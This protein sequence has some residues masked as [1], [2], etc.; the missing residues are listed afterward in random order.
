MT[1]RIS[2]RAIACALLATTCLCLPTIAL[3]DSP[4]PK[5]I[6]AIDD[7]EVDLV[8]GLPFLSIEEGGIGS[9]P[10]RVA[11]TR[12]WA[13][14]AGFQDNWSGGLFD[15]T[16]GGVTKK[17]VQINGISDTFTQSGSTYTADKANGATL[18]YDS[19]T[20]QFVY[21]ASDGTKITFNGT[22]G[23]GP[24]G[25]GDYCPGS[26]GA[27]CHVPTLIV[28]PNGLKFTLSW[29]FVTL[30]LHHIGVDCDSEAVYFRLRSVSS[31]AGYSMAISYATNSA[32]TGTEP[33]SLWY[34]R[35]SVTFNNSANP[36]SP[37]SSISYAYPSSTTT[38]VTDPASRTW[39]FTT[40]ANG[41]LTGVQRPGSSSNN[42][43][44]AYGA[45]GTISSVTKDGVTNSYSRST[46]G[47]TATET[48]TN[49]LSQQRV[50]TTD[51]SKGRPTS[52]KD[53]LNRT[54]SYQYDANV[55]MTRITAPEGNYV[56]YD[57]DARGNVNTTT[58][59]A[60]AGSGLANIVTNANF[61]ATCTNIVKCNKPNSTTDAKGNVTNYTYDPTHGG[62]LTITSPAPSAGAV[63]PQTRIT[64]SQVTSASGDLVY[65]PTKTAACQTLASC[66]NGADEAQVITAY[67]GNLLPTS[68]TRQDGTATL[69]S[70]STSTYDPRGNVLTVDGQLA[71]SGDT[72]R[73]RYDNADQL[74]GVTSPDPDGSGPLK[75]RAV[76]YSYNPDGTLWLAQYGTV[77]DQSD[78]AW[79]NFAE[80]YHHYRQYDS[81]AHVIRE[82]LWSNGVDYAVT[83]H[84]YDGLGR[85]SCSVQYMDPAVWGPQ[86]T[87]CAPLQTN[88]PNGPDRVTQTVY[89][90]AS[91]P[92]Q[93][94]VAVGT[95]DA[96]TERTLTYSNNGLVTSLTDGESNKTS[97]VYDGFDRLSQ[98]QY[99][100]ATKGAGTSNA[101][102]YEQLGY[103]AAS[104]VTSRRLRDGTS[105]AYGYDNLDRVTLK[106]LPGSESDV[107][108]S[109]DLLGRLTG[110]S[111]GGYNLTF[112]YDALSRQTSD[113]QGWG[114]ISRSFDAAGR[115]TRLTWQDGFYV[116][117]DRLVTGELSKVRE[118]GATSGVGVLATYGYDDLGRRTSLTFGN[119][120]SQVYSYDAVGRLASLTNDLSGT[121]N[122][123]SVTFA[124]NPASQ[125]AS[126]VRT[127]D[128]YAFTGLA[129]ANTGY[130]QNGLNQQVTIG[131]SSASWDARGNL[132]AD[133]A[134]GKTYTYN[135]ENRLTSA[136]GGVSLYYDPIGRLSEYDTNVSS[137]FM[138]D[139]AEIAVEVDNPAGNVVRRFVRGDGPDELIAWYEG[140]G[141]SNRRFAST[142][143]RGSVISATDSSGALVGI[144]TYD[145]YGKPG[146]AS[147]GR[148]QYTGQMW[149]PEA[150]VYNYKAR[151]YSPT[152]GRFM[153]TDPIGYGNGPNWYAYVGSDPVNHTDPLGLRWITRCVGVV[154][155]TQCDRVWVEDPVTS[156]TNRDNSLKSPG[157][158]NGGPSDDDSPI[159]ITAPKLKPTIGRYH[160]YQIVRITQ[161]SAAEAFDAFKA[162][163]ASAPGAP[164]A[165]EG[166][167]DR[168]VLN[169]NNPIS[170]YVNTKNM[171]IINRALP[172]HRYFPG[173]VTIQVSP[174]GS[175]S[176]ITIVGTGSGARPAENLLTGNAFFG[177]IATAIMQGCAILEGNVPSFG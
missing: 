12:I 14:G 105:I 118:N 142:D 70:T 44:F 176:K 140:S 58:H 15:V 96:A 143:E 139:G 72:T 28:A 79:S 99:P 134:S 127:G 36:P 46:V 138:S 136:S 110:A 164:Q 21:T 153:Q 129:N 165:R 11:M 2:R 77:T 123:L 159:V 8:T 102:D 148:F 87:S 112:G 116:D 25:T 174:V 157:D 61:D 68:V 126:A 32:G 94:K 167:T 78:S 154:G 95:S 82:T 24:A 133:P 75:D 43:S 55:R 115:A 65:M 6:D 106:D 124:Y 67:N 151:M 146:S 170:Q 29:D 107:S 27:S 97:Y 52:D 149:L 23:T 9:G 168:L 40:D 18:V 51:T 162:P 169:G 172:G 63:Q 92:T 155:S 83:D 108:Y 163:G 80:A 121:A 135:S 56:R 71:G 160:R 156:W 103:D 113:G 89:D 74:I 5:F 22:M 66:A 30:C 42:I 50:V 104:N 38:T 13:E 86:A 39:T 120:A 54:T 33:S 41:R 152:L 147:V 90:D 177:G 1:T 150:G 10:G 47:T 20:T 60:K 111:Q 122:D 59:V 144:N 175:G 62:V 85:L 141:T 88:G 173:T 128:A 84:V 4:A 35:T 16:S 137:R 125:I 48:R 64:Y 161:C 100:S 166:F 7:H 76:K 93:L 34:R 19:S 45:D 114:T 171:T 69:V 53:G 26:V 119:G 98:T 49:P 73:Y 117:Y 57:Y 109:Y 81:N 31:S 101:S 17:Y 131:A 132:T 3:A 145:E 37:A 130:T 158:R 91:Q